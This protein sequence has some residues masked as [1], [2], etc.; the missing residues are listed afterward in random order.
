MNC[1]CRED[2]SYGE[3]GESCEREFSLWHVLLLVLGSVER[4]D[5]AA[6][7]PSVKPEPKVS[8]LLKNYFDSCVTLFEVFL[9]HAEG[10]LSFMAIRL[11]LSCAMKF[12]AEEVVEAQMNALADN[13]YPRADH[14]LEVHSQSTDSPIS[15]ISLFIDEYHSVRMKHLFCWSTL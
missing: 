6:T 10:T 3:V 5:A 15:G 8:W 14:G 11:R 1:G 2:S 13:D 7:G 12:A 4:N 9:F